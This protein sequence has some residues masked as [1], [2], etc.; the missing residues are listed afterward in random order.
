[1]IFVSSLVICTLLEYLTGWYLE[2]TWGVKW[3]D[4]SGMSL[5]LH[6]RICF[7]GSVMF[8]IGGMLLV[9]VISPLFYS[10]YCQVPVRLRNAIGLVVI[11]LLLADAAYIA[12]ITHYGAGITY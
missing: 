7:L 10:L 11:L 6:G 2:L 12:I 8:G 1:M 5:N 4:Y 3:W 9:W